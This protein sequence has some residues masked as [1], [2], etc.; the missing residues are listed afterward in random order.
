MLPARP[1]APLAVCEPGPGPGAGA[2]PLS[3][4]PW[5]L[6]PPGD[7][8]PTRCTP[9]ARLVHAHTRADIAAARLLLPPSEL[10]P[11]V[12]LFI[13]IFIHSPCCTLLFNTPSRT[14]AASPPLPPPRLPGS[15][16]KTLHTYTPRDASEGFPDVLV[17]IMERA[18][19]REAG[20]QPPRVRRC[21]SHADLHSCGVNAK[22]SRRRPLNPPPRS[23]PFAAVGSPHVFHSVIS[24]LCSPS[25]YYI[26][27]IVLAATLICV[28][29]EE[30]V[31]LLWPQ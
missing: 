3:F 17:Y 15:G 24:K 30:N 10:S 18:T 12:S 4:N 7:L 5:S 8:M 27:M 1:P 16:R 21:E 20:S 26:A 13:Y 2:D 6:Q 28:E 14:P 29:V 31:E 25:S 19:H 9:R 23:R 11:M 22:C